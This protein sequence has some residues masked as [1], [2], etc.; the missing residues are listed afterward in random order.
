MLDKISVMQSFNAGKKVEVFDGVSWVTDENPSWNWE[1]YEYRV[2]KSFRKKVVEALKEKDIGYRTI[3]FGCN[4]DW[5]NEGSKKILFDS[6]I[7]NTLKA[8]LEINDVV[9]FYL[10]PM[11]DR[12]SEILNRISMSKDDRDEP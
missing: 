2:A 4:E 7:R 10:V 11:S 1:K 5:N 6:H 12:G 8:N 3:T 9:K